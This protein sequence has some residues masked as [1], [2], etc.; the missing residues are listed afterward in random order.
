MMLLLGAGMISTLT[1]VRIA[2][3]YIFDSHKT[4]SLNDILICIYVYL[5]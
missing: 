1:S 5:S 2:N 3:T 4:I